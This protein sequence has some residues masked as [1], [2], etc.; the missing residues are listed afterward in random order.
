M[1]AESEMLLW[2]GGNAFASCTL[3]EVPTF[4][5]FCMHAPCLSGLA[6]AGCKLALVG[7][8]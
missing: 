4:K 2:L 1:L 6:H 7:Y 8:A 5:L 3:N